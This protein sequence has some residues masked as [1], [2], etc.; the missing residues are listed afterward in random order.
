MMSIV[1]V[2]VLA[3]IAL[4]DP[5]QEP[6][7][8]AEPTPAQTEPAA[9]DPAEP[10]PTKPTSD[11]AKG[12]DAGGAKLGDPAPKPVEEP[13]NGPRTL[14]EKLAAEGWQEFDRV[15]VIVNHN[16]IT[17]QQVLREMK[18]RSGGRKLRQDEVA[19]LHDQVL[20]DYVNRA[21][22]SQAGQDLGA[23]EKLVD[24]QVR[25]WFDGLVEDKGGIVAFTKI[26]EAE[27]RTSQEVR[28][29]LRQ[30]IYG[31]NWRR[32]ITGEGTGVGT[33]PGKDR[34]IRPGMLKFRFVN[35][36][37]EPAAYGDLGGK[38]ETYSLQRILLDPGEHGGP[39][40]T[41]ELAN[42]LRRRIVD[43]DDM[44]DLV[45]KFSSK[46]DQSKDGIIRD[47]NAARMKK[48]YPDLAA[49]A[50]KAQPGDVSSPI[51]LKA[52]DKTVLQ[53]VRIVD[54]TSAV[55]PEFSSTE[56][57]QAITKSAQQALDEYRTTRAFGQL[58]E[59]AYIWPE[60]MR[61]AD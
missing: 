36:I 53:I 32:W 9:Q 46:Q 17:R 33:R 40:K 15:G 11:E 30:N 3:L 41:L 29:D 50:D 7:K 56:V 58:Y 19:R 43:G 59:T 37:Q 23:D 39:E 2:F 24:L 16:I 60:T 55:R 21:L 51:P 6:P 34:F 27:G 54:K 61:A 47:L 35:S 52:D 31:R 49:F 28:H 42:D 8:P 22:A 26:L 45:Q 10:Q 44:T 12:T 38:A 1:P 18:R 13:K 57:Q 5:A 4:Q 14:E 48:T 20:L 25:T